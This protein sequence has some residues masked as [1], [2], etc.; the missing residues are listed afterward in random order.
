MSKRFFGG[1]L[2]P[3]CVVL[4]LLLNACLPEVTPSPTPLPTATETVIPTATGTIVWFPPTAT[5]TPAPT[6][7]VEPTPDLR[8]ALGEMILSDDFADTSQW[9]TS[10]MAAGSVAYGRGELTL[11][12]S[13]AKGSLLSLRKTPQLYNFYAEIDTLPSLCRDGDAYGLLIRAGSSEDFYR[14]LLNC[15]GQVRMERVKNSKNALLYDWMVSGQ[16][17]P[18]GMLRARLG[19][20]ARG[21]DLDVYVNDVYQFSVKD[22]VFT[23]G[24]VGVFARAAGDTPL[25]VNFSNLVIYSLDAE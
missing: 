15:A 7:P 16:L 17:Q 6:I 13:Q 3:A 1:I 10:R 2:W 24:V 25:T 23:S 14:I 11:A 20:A 5:F 12:V 4:S 21:P 8:P 18:G 9:G 22:P 19:V